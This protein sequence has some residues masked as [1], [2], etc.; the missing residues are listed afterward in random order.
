MKISHGDHDLR[1]DCIGNPVGLV[2]IIKF[3]FCQLVHDERNI[4]AV[5]RGIDPVVLPPAAVDCRLVARPSLVVIIGR[6]DL[7]RALPNVV[8]GIVNKPGIFTIRLPF[9]GTAQLVL[10]RARDID[11]I[12]VDSLR[13]GG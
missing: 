5:G 13:P 11:T 7:E 12:R 9:T 4:G 3:D 2:V 10:V 8:F 1:V 6:L